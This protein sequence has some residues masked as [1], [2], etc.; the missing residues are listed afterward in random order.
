MD[1]RPETLSPDTPF[2]T[3]PSAQR[4]CAMLESAGYQAYFVGGCVRN[5]VIGAP[6]SD[7]DIA[8]DARPA[9]VVKLARSDGVKA[10]PTGIDH[11]TVTLV[12]DGIPFEV[13]TFRRDVETDGRRAVVAFSDTMVEDARR[14]DFTMNAIYADA[15]GVIHDPVDGLR[16]ARAGRVRFIDDATQRIAEDYLRILRFFRFSAWYGDPALGW[17]PE[18]LAAISAG[19]H[20]LATLSAERVGAEMLKLLAAP[21]PAPAVG[22]M[23]QTGVLN[24][25]LPGGDPQFIAPLVHFEGQANMG[26]DPY[27][28]LAALGGDDVVSRL[29]LSR[30][31]QKRLEAIRTM[32]GTARGPRALGH[33]VGAEAAVGAML[34]RAAMAL[35]DL[36]H[37]WMDAISDGA[38]TEFPVRAADLPDL[39]GPTL[40]QRL[41]SLKQDWL[42]S[43]LTLSREALLQRSQ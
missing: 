4:V 16:D 20:G 43:D 8:T 14:R 34:L 22:V 21:D 37:G 15:R 36:P 3:D 38:R 27:A 2:L 18:A 31:G 12:I 32:A 26:P 6:V 25:L 40:G 24:A 17:D 13:T 1:R 33:L 10:V 19:L 7:I 9:A 42:A 23:A 39:D 30:K 5:A 41:K 29:R 35:G 11:G 28:R